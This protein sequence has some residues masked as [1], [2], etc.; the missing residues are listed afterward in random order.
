MV[1]RRYR[2]SR[3]ETKGL[4]QRKSCGWPGS[5]QAHRPPVTK[6]LDVSNHL[7]CLRL[8]RIKRGIKALDYFNR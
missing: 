5:A 6:V 2:L 3:F 7:S 1:R 8:I 4:M